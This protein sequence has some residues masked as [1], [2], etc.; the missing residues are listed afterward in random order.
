MTSGEVSLGLV[1]RAV[2]RRW[3]IGLTFLLVAWG[4]TISFVL[5]NGLRYEARMTITTVNPNRGGLNL[6]SGASSL[7]GGLGQAAGLQATPA[8]VAKL[9]RLNG[10]LAQVSHTAFAGSPGGTIGA[11][12]F[13]ENCG[14]DVRKA[15]P[16]DII[17]CLRNALVVSVD[18]V[19][20]F[21]ELT[22]TARDSSLARAVA[23]RVVALTSEAYIGA[24]RSQATLVRRGQEARVD[25][26]ARRLRSAEDTLLAFRSSNRGA[27]VFSDASVVQARLERAASVAQAVYT[28]AVSERET[29]VGKEFES[30]PAFVILDPIPT[31]L[32]RK[33]RGTLFYLLLV[34][35]IYGAIFSM[36]AVYRQRSAE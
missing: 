33:P 8:V 3:R 36:F 29:A 9:M 6:P 16:D 11:V 22:V 31:E 34:T 32:P 15:S 12:M 14:D 26:A 27:S 13:A 4:S 28:Q 24:T 20:G 35:L 25:T 7:L 21:I 19:T 1:Y 30:T 2:L 18:Q 23:L 10:V 5:L 17:R